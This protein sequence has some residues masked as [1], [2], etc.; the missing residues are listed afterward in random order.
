M[1]SSH[2]IT[3]LKNSLIEFSKELQTTSTQVISSPRPAPQRLS[4][5][6]KIKDSTLRRKVTELETDLNKACTHFKKVA[7]STSLGLEDQVL[8]YIIAKNNLPIDIFTLDTGRLF[9]ETYELLHETSH[10]YKPIR[11]Y[12]P[13]TEEIETYV[14]THGINGFKEAIS[15]RKKCC[16]IRKIHPLKRALSQAELWITGIRN[17]QSPERSTAP[18]LE[19]A[20][21]YRI[22]KFNPLIH[23]SYEETR[24]VVKTYKILYNPLHDNGFPSI[25]C[26]PCTRAVKPNE[27]A[28]AGRWWWELS[29]TRE[30]GLHTSSS[31]TQPSISS[32]T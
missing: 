12:Y 2:H 13:N 11:V 10:K 6:T 30:C 9:K 14:T 18:S 17:E 28:R 5:T 8:T 31:P 1:S 24:T 25:G 27:P 3:T 15:L 16:A 4:A 32:T 20:H 23:W 29:T 19:I 7:F 21:E 22:I 26:A